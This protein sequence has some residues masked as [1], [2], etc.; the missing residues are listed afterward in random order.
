M[1][2]KQQDIKKSALDREQ[3]G[4]KHQTVLLKREEWVNTIKWTKTSTI[5]PLQIAIELISND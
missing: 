5:V 1:V 4:P 2:S 3:F